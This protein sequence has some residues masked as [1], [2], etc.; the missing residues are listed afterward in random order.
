MFPAGKRLGMVLAMGGP[1]GARPL[2]AHQK[3]LRFVKI[4]N[5][6][7]NLTNILHVYN[8]MFIIVYNIP[9]RSQRHLPVGQIKVMFYLSSGHGHLQYSQQS[10]H[11]NT[12][13]LF[14]TIRT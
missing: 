3:V 7:I 10:S 1:L 12:S 11:V 13:I 8:N 14:L 2:P 5:E 4:I 6:S 9:L